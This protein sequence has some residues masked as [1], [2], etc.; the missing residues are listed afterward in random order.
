MATKVDVGVRQ[1]QEMR[2]ELGFR[3][4]TTKV[5]P[6]LTEDNMKKRK[7]WALKN[8]RSKLTHVVDYDFW[9]CGSGRKTKSLGVGGTIYQAESSC[10][11]LVT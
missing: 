2:K 4:S 5:R 6:I 3:G 1:A 8:R 9:W 7:A 10:F 11:I